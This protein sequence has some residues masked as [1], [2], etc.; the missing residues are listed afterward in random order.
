MDLASQSVYIYRMIRTCSMKQMLRR[1][2]TPS[3]S[4]K[5]S[6]VLAFDESWVFNRLPWQLGEGISHDQGTS[7][8]LS[9][10]VLLAVPT[11]QNQNKKGGYGCSPVTSI[12]NIVRANEH[13]ENR[14]IGS[15]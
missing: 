5:S 8:H 15:N 6:P 1:K 2:H 10:T 11:Y 13:G 14:N 7:L 12:E 9:E 4:K 3:T